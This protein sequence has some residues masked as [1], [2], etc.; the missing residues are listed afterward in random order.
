LLIQT[1]GEVIQAQPKRGAKSA[2]SVLWLTLSIPMD[3]LGDAE[4]AKLSR[5]LHGPT[6]GLTLDLGPFVAAGTG[7]SGRGQQ[8]TIEDVAP[9]R[10]RRP[11]RVM[12]L[13]E[14]RCQRCYDRIGED[15]DRRFYAPTLGTPQP[16][17]GR[18]ADLS[19]AERDQAATLGPPDDGA[20]E[21]IPG[22]EDGPA[23]GTMQPTAAEVAP[24]WVPVPT[25]LPVAVGAVGAEGEALEEWPATTDPRPPRV[26][27]PEAAAAL[28]DL[29]PHLERVAASTDETFEQ[30]VGPSAATRRRRSKA[31]T[32]A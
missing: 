27:D 26:A 29:P 21:V 15:P 6:I 17:H 24:G 10:A 9:T 30:L 18:C 7:A 1:R 11:E 8:A 20:V 28:G 25:E 5:F 23:P 2:P 3:G 13:P 31:T 14:E 22:E 32:G 19:D 12:P 16:M 4:I